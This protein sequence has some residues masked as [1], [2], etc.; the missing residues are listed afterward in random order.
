M[1][2]FDIVGS[3]GNFLKKERESKNLSLEEVS[4]S[5]RIKEHFLKAIEE[6]RFDLCPSPFYVKGFLTHYARFLGLDPKDIIL[7]YREL[8]KPLLL[9]PE[10][11]VQEKPKEAFQFHPRIQTRIRAGTTFRLLLGSALFISLLIPLYFY[12]AYQ[13]LKAPDLPALSRH[14]PVTPEVVPENQQKP[15]AR[16]GTPEKENPP[17]LLQIKR[18]E[19]IGPQ[20]VQA[21]SFYDVTDAHLGTGIETESGRPMV[22]GI[23]SEFKCENQ[24]VYF[25]TRI[26]TP[27]EGK[28]FHVWRREGEEFHRIEMSVNPPTWSV[29]SYITLPPARSGNWKVE[30]WEGDKLLRDLSFKAHSPQGSSSPSKKKG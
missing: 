4:K 18:M 28:I 6:D 2:L 24:R 9:P 17:I 26:S 10:V 1:S 13:P 16:E 21:E 11:T 3:I 12:V 23:G 5:T 19:L 27:K 8:M 29:Y 25:F 22:V 20:E 14:K 30:V 15:I 7:K